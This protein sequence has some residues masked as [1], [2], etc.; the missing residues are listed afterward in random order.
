MSLK[1]RPANPLSSLL[2]QRLRHFVYWRRY[3]LAT[4]T[5]LRVMLFGLGLGLAFSLVIFFVAQ[6]SES[7]RLLE[8]I[9]GLVST[10][11]T[12]ARIA[13]F[14]GD[15]TLATEVAKG[16][17]ANRAVAAVRITSDT[18][19][20][21][22]LNKYAD[23][24]VAA[25]PGTTVSRKMHSPFNEAD[26]VGEVILVADD[27]YIRE[28]ARSSSLFIVILSL[29]EMLI[30]ALAVAWVVLRTI[31]RPIREFSENL[32]TLDVDSG[33]FAEYPKG[34]ELN[35]VGQLADS[36]NNLLA[37]LFKLVKNEKELGAQLAHKESQFRALAEN[38]P[39]SIVR[40]SLDG[41][42][43]YCNPAY[44]ANVGIAPGAALDT[45]P[46]QM[47]RATNFSGA[48]FQ[49][50]LQNVMQ[51]STPSNV[52][53]EWKK[54]NGH[55]VSSD[56][57]L[58]PECDASGKVSSVLA[59]GH[60][61]SELKKQQRLD[62]DRSLVFER[63][64]RGGELPE[65]LGMV[66]GHVEQSFKAYRCAIL[67]LDETCGC[68]RVG[69]APGLPQEYR[70]A[71]DGC[72]ERFPLYEDRYDFWLAFETRAARHGLNL[73]LYEPV[74]DSQQ[75]LLGILALYRQQSD[76][77]TEFD[78]N[79]MRQ[80][81]SMAALAIERHRFEI[82]VQHQA[83]YDALTDLP[84]RRMFMQKLREEISRGKRSS[85]NVT[86]LFIDLDR[87]KGVNDTLGHETGDLLLVQAARRIRGCMREYDTV[88]RLGGDEFVA[89]IADVADIAVLG[90]VAKAIVDALCTPFELNG[91]TAY[92]SA[93]I[94]IASF[95][96][97]CDNPEQLVSFADQAMYAAKNAGRNGYQFY[98]EE[99]SNNA[100]ERLKLELDL[101]Q[102]MGR[103]EL[104]LYY[105]P[106]V[107]LADGSLTGSEALV[108]WNHPQRGLV[109]PEE[110][111][112]IAEDSG[113]IAELG[114]H[115]L[116]AAC[117][118]A[119]EWNGGGKPLH[120]LAVNLSARQ[121][122]SGNLYKTVCD[123]LRETACQPEWI[124]LEITE[125]LLLEDSG[126]VLMTLELFQEMGITIAIDDFGTGY[127]ALSY[128]A[129]FPID[130]LKIDQSFITHVA[131]DGYHAEL[132]KAI[133]TIAHSLNQQVVAEGV[134]TLEQAA[135]LTAC[136]CH[137]AQGYLYGKP[138]AKS[139]F[140]AAWL[141]LERESEF[142]N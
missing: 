62:A 34:N 13:C 7:A 11:E 122:M 115:V 72:D 77:G 88:A 118:T 112:G 73:C 142:E 128:L 92:I 87:F 111:I 123:I 50:I 45:T 43:I 125:S 96:S 85:G 130:T 19:L 65:V 126:I 56:F 138:V 27:A 124:E 132:V 61:I 25:M 80:A 69:A 53:L 15:P 6:R 31:V 98:S 139:T 5:A 82:L 121:F 110:F 93:S 18:R 117:H 99:L 70:A 74:H 134:N 109:M 35:E 83:S 21:A 120:K 51:S 54:E 84:N 20:L 79:F 119:R 52:L 12:T 103:G 3:S 68:L 58:V 10:V 71:V 8:N 131:D 28:Q 38:S 114:E 133:I 32:C 101:R 44:D 95:P 64:V 106:K 81:C 33:E 67:L 94:G 76:T 42:R 29:L 59:L 22:Q 1:I 55:L 30:I 127:S 9:S 140:K 17:L 135:I 66:A 16:L 39:N 47:W 40:Y 137:I 4:A 26:T 100:N 102:G 129:R 57:H 105:Q 91:N 89:V 63:M 75:R 2:P 48:E 78:I 86:L 49:S 136:G 116:R 46:E 108:R 14:T 37:H 23:R 113:L 97:H 107:S 141:A 60:D 36:F 41:R 104:E 90:G 24:P